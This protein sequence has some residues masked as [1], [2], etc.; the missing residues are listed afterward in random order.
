MKFKVGNKVKIINNKSLEGNE[1]GPYIKNGDDHII[2]GIVLDKK[3]NQHLDIGVKS[4]Y[5]Y[6]TSYETGEE[7]PNGDTIQWCHP[8]RFELIEE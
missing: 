4:P 8:S 3:G 7:L 1:N 2:I 6:V 5:S